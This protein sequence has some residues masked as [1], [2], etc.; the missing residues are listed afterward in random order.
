MRVRIRNHVN[1][2]GLGF[3]HFRGQRPELPAGVPV[4]LEVGCADAQFLFELA[5]RDAGR[6]YVGLEIRE[7]L[8]DAVNREAVKL[9]S[10][11]NAVFCHA[12]RH[13][14]ELFAE[15]SVDRVFVNFPDPWFKRRQRKRRMVDP[16]LADQIVRAL[17]P[18]GELLVQTDV[19]LV[20]LDAL[21]SFEGRDDALINL[22][23]EWGFW[24]RGNPY[25]VRSWRE[26]QCERKGRPIWRL[27]Y[28]RTAA[29]SGRL[30]LELDQ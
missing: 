30:R 29:P 2:L 3:V 14:H 25:G 20:A 19:W 24:K 23:S 22:D 13:M 1:P 12:N 16:L 10:P 9:G 28:R 27:L 15:A 17:R 18:G 21:E 4:D 5:E 6:C 7:E 26:Q 11:V 8:V